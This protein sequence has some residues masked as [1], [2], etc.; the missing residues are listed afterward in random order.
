[1][2][3]SRSAR[4]G[5]VLAIAIIVLVVFLFLALGVEYL[6]SIQQ[7]GQSVQGQPQKDQATG[8]YTV[9]VIVSGH[10]DF[11]VV[12]RN[13]HANIH[14]DFVTYYYTTP[15]QPPSGRSWTGFSKPI[16]V[17]VAVTSTSLS[18]PQQSSFDTLVSL[19]ARWGQVLNYTLPSGTFTIVAQGLDQDGYTS[20]SAAQLTLP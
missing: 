6:R 8:L 12:H 3:G 20:S 7:P 19:A 1:M 11:T 16:H 2:T 17:T 5:N 4:R 15:P 9:Y 10:R 14:V 18:A 13:L